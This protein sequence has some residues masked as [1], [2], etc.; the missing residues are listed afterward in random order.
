MIR[1]ITVVTSRFVVA[2]CVCVLGRLG[3]L[4]ASVSSVS[5]T[6]TLVPWLAGNRRLPSYCGPERLACVDVFVSM[7][8]LSPVLLVL[9]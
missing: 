6:T 8:V 3:L 9:A 7:G 4:M 1:F 2:V 5:R